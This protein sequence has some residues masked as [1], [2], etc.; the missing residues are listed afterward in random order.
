[1]FRRETDLPMTELADAVEHK[2]DDDLR[3]VLEEDYDALNVEKESIRN[4]E[5]YNT[6]EEVVC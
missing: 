3:F 4:M 2:N 5:L 6:E 1:M